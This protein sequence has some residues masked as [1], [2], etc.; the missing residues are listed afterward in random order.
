MAPFDV[1]GKR[2]KP[3][4][5]RKDVCK[6]RFQSC[7]KASQEKTAYAAARLDR[8][9]ARVHNFTEHQ[10]AIPLGFLE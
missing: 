5:I 10:G 7:R 9:L 2:V 4:H 3:A 8:T 1:Q 6:A